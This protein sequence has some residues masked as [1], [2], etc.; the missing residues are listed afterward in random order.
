M[1]TVDIELEKEISYFFGIKDIERV[2]DCYFR[3]FSQKDE[4]MLPILHEAYEL[5]ESCVGWSFD[6]WEAAKIEQEIIYAFR[7]CASFEEIVDLYKKIYSVIFGY[8]QDS[9]DKIAQLRAF[10]FTYQRQGELS[11]PL[12]L[13][14]KSFL[15]STARLSEHYLQEFERLAKSREG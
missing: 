4:E 1:G 8:P 6:T 9:F 2:A 13:E 15:V 14:D 12:T 7:K 11:G 5:I 3:I 10:L